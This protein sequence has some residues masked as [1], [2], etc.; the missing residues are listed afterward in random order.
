MHGLHGFH[1]RLGF[2]AKKGRLIYKGT[3]TASASGIHIR[4][5]RM[6][7][8]TDGQVGWRQCNGH[9]ISTSSRL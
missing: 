8:R 1:T 3:G 7:E 9:D 6:D 5:E 4:E 2:Q